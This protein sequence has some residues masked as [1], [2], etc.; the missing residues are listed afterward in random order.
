MKRDI[1]EFVAKCL[2]CQ[3]VKIEHHKALGLLQH[4]EIPKWKWDNVAI[5]FVMGLPRTTSRHDGIW[6]IVDRLTKSGNFLAI[7]ATYSLDK[8]A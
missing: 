4:L 2:T 6:V 5:D 8:L 3:K 7:R 1:A